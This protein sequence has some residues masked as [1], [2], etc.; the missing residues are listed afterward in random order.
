[1]TQWLSVLRT[2][3]RCRMNATVTLIISVN[4]LHILFLELTTVF[5]ASLQYVTMMYYAI[6]F[7]NQNFESR[8]KLLFPPPRLLI[9]QLLHPY[10]LQFYFYFK[11][12]L[13]L[14]KDE[15]KQSAL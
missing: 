5:S 10:L 14:N 11:C 3:Q 4:F 8:K 1:M 2:E 12:F 7:K 9:L 13:T 15:K 6:S